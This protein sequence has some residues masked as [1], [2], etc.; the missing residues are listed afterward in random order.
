M[1]AESVTFSN[2]L[3]NMKEG[4]T[5]TTLNSAHKNENISINTKNEKMSVAGS[6]DTGKKQK[7]KKVG[8]EV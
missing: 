1:N 7:E 4:Q 5:Y 6:N 2:E 3:K 8:Y